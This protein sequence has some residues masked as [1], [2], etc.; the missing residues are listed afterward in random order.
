[1]GGVAAGIL[2][3][4]S[5]QK[6]ES[7]ALRLDIQGLRALA[8]LLVV[9]F[10]LWPAGVSGGYIGVDVFFV[11]SGYLI[12]GH[13]LRE[14]VTTGRVSVT[15]FWAR[16][17]RRLLPAAFLVL[18]VCAV[19]ALLVMPRA[20][21]QE[22]LLEIG[23]AGLYVLNWVL[24]NNAVDYLGATN[25]DSIVQHYWSL[26][27]EEQFYIVW[28][29]IILAVLWVVSKL[30]RAR[31]Q[32]ALM[33]AVFLALT[34]V[35]LVS[36]AYSVWQ[37]HTS[38]ASA[39]FI[40]T[41]RAWEFAA[42][43]VVAMLPTLPALS[44]R[45]KGLVA[46][47]SWALLLVILACALLFDADTAFPGWIAVVPVAATAALIWIGD[48]DSV[49]APQFLA[50]SGPVQF[51]GNTSYAIYLWHWPLIVL[52]PLVTHKAI[53]LKS[54]LAIIALSVAL[55][56]ATKY[57]VEDPAR[58]A[59]GRLR[60]RWPAYS[61]A[62][63]GMAAVL[64]LTLT[65]VLVANA[66][67]QAY[68]ARISAAIADT[69]GCFGAYAILNA[70]P[71]P[72]AITDTVNPQYTAQDTYKN[73]GLPSTDACI[74]DKVGR[75]LDIQC[76]AGRPFS[77]RKIALVGD[78]H[79]ASL[80]ASLSVAADRLGWELSVRALTG[81]SGF[82]PPAPPAANP[83]AEAVYCQRWG[84]RVFDD[85]AADPETT[86]VIV[87]IRTISKSGPSEELT[88]KRLETLVDAGKRLIIIGFVP[89]MQN[90]WPVKT[91]VQSAPACVEEHPKVPDPCSWSPPADYQ[92]WL[93]TAA[94]TVGAAVI[95]P[96][97]VL[98]GP[99]GRCHAV[100]GGTIVYADDN[101]LSTTFALTL[102]PFLERHLAEI[103]Q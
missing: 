85:L 60:A 65:P 63:T 78:S 88:V 6:R 64:A 10:H 93:I 79:A 17:I 71:D 43:G 26:S 103:L 58:N 95:D 50:R 81:C 21:L 23:A 82:Q 37:T 83:S 34:A 86:A 62:A 53:G 73:T 38:A 30:A 97:E 41:T 55:A 16:R 42:G 19:L 98:C 7:T 69:Q 4:Q 9:V 54:G 22:N 48:T 45:L 72:Y 100:I 68:K 47:T 15:R 84:D 70:C 5:T 29:L 66:Q 25:P 94:H 90:T 61:F 44:A 27:V 67:A 96:R 35:F 18:L 77:T 3:G 57:L 101:H 24:A 74:E 13:L 59:R 51:L 36:F 1:M 92:D 20:V 102:S 14:V 12:T 33:R 99:D 40:T 52:Y 49:W 76:E 39:Y 32:R 2:S 56:A 46:A 75:Q 91:V 87:D 28:P 11:I 8:V 89:G 80:A 31:S